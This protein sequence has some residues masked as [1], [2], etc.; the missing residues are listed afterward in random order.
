ERGA[1]SSIVKNNIQKRTVDTQLA[2]VLDEPQFAK[3]IHEEAHPGA[4]GANHLGEGFL[5][6]FG[7]HGLWSPFFAEPGKQQQRPRQAFFAGVEEL[8]NQIFLK[9]NVTGQ[10]IA[11]E[12]LRKRFLIVEH[13]HHLFSVNPEYRRRRESCGGGHAPR[14]HGRD[15]LFS[16]EVPGT[17]YRYSRF[18]AAFG[19]DG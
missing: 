18:L 14:L 2:V 11:D 8:I 3:A 16:Q 17:K 4:G 19:D 1:L 12:N 10:Q 5:A 6:D 15:A 13:P 7:N 9:T